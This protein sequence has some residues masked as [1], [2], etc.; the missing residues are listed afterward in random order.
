MSLF[1]ALHKLQKCKVKLG[2]ANTQYPTP[3]G[4]IAYGTIMIPLSFCIAAGFFKVFV[5]PSG[6]ATFLDAF[7]NWVLILVGTLCAI[8]GLLVIVPSGEVEIAVETRRIRRGQRQKARQDESVKRAQRTAITSLASAFGGLFE[9]DHVF[10][11]DN[12]ARDFLQWSFKCLSFGKSDFLWSEYIA[13]ATTTMEEGTFGTYL[14]TTVS[15]RSEEAKA[16]VAIWTNEAGGFKWMKL[17]FDGGY[18]KAA[19]TMEAVGRNLGLEE[20]VDAYY[21]GVPLE[22]ILN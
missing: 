14:D 10:S 13:G 4:Y 21:S 1:P 22:T 3:K 8:A 5:I 9:S 2:L 18:E 11:G 12:G 15:Q 6:Q 16:L 17:A 19:K 7:P 20:M